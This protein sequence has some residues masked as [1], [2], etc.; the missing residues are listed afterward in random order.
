[1][2]PGLVCD[3][4]V[5]A[6]AVIGRG[7]LLA[8]DHAHEPCMQVELGLP[9]AE[10]TARVINKLPPGSGGVIAVDAE[11]NCALLHIPACCYQTSLS[12]LAANGQPF[13]IDCCS[14]LLAGAAPFNSDVLF[15]GVATSQSTEA[16]AAIGSGDGIT[17]AVQPDGTGAASAKL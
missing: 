10:A 13:L 3:L 11:G 4:S 12:R 9:L 6:A 7:N 8:I 5:R 14:F 16:A 17:L 2:W 15:R 1:M